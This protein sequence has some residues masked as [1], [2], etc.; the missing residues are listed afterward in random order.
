MKELKNEYGRLK[1]MYA[2]VRLVNIPDGV[3]L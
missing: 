2:E 1:K 3:I